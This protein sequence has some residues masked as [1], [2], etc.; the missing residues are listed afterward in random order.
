MNENNKF[1]FSQFYPSALPQLEKY[2]DNDIQQ[3]YAMPP[4]AYTE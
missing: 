4:A 1:Y 2:E 3:G